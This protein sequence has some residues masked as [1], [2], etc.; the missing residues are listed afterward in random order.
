[1]AGPRKFNPPF[2]VDHVGSFLRPPRL[3]EARERAGFRGIGEPRRDGEISLDEL[4]EV[5]NDCIREVVQLQESMGL[6][7]I[8]DGE[9]R[10]NSWAIDIVERMKGVEIRQQSG[11]FNATFDGSEFHPPVPHTVAK[12]GRTEGGLVLDDYLFTSK[13]T[14]RMV[15]ACIPAP[16]IIYLRG[17]RDA[18]SKE[19]YPDIEDFFEDLMALYREEIAAL[20]GAG[21]RYVQLD[22]VD[23]AMIC[24]PKFQE[25]SRKQGMEPID[26]VRLH[27]RLVNGA[28]RDLPSDM[29]G[30][31]H[32]CRGNAQGHW[33]AAGGY[34]Y[35]AEVL[36]N[37]FDV[38]AFF[39]EYD[40]PRAGDFA[41]L[42]FAPKDCLIVLGIMTTKTPEHDSKDVLKRRIEEAA[43]YVPLENLAVSP[44][45]GFASVSLGNPITV[46]DERRKIAL[47]YEVAEE[48]W[49]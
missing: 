35:V 41:P 7:A 21:C 12:L 31:M 10:R 25:L 36:F 1:M 2:R 17:G 32:L 15:K 8:T 23:T 14:D 48:V 26:Q 19:T 3:L 16:S 37:E 30:A 44:Q 29:A 18:V 39:L 42:R 4:R 40:S 11:A 46:D 5:E 6:R 22:N 9:F 20:Y 28:Y 47:L 38:D 33:L 27:A 43:Q 13:L 45:C 49:G 34:E 24:D